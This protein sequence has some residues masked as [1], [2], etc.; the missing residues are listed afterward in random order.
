VFRDNTAFN[1]WTDLTWGLLTLCVDFHGQP[2]DKGSNQPSPGRRRGR[3]VYRA[4]MYQAPAATMLPSAE[5]PMAKA[6]AAQPLTVVEDAETGN[7]FVNYATK[8][9]VHLELQFDGEEPW[10]TQRD[11]ASLF[12][13]HADTVGD[14]IDK[15]MADGELDESTTGKFPVVQQEDGRTVRRDIKHY[16]LDVAFYVGYRVNSTEGKLFRRWATQMLVQLATHG[17]VVDKRRHKGAPDR[18]SKLRE[19]TLV[20]LANPPR[21]AANLP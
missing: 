9:G 20:K 18:L 15:F 3:A 19:P 4:E 13:V 2:P 6:A 10:F 7:R 16:N 11:L 8:T 21:P 1:N 5:R 14:H 17:F 12:G